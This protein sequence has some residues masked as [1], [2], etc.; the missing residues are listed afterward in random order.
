MTAGPLAVHAGGQAGEA[1]RAACGT[2]LGVLLALAAGCET[3]SKSPVVFEERS[4]EAG[5]D[6]VHTDGSSGKYFITET[7]ASGVGLFDYDGDGDLDIYFV[8]GRPLPTGAA[9]AESAKG[10]TGRNALFRNEGAASGV[11]PKFTDVTAGA[12]VPGTG[13]GIACCAGDYDSDGDLD[14]FVTQ[15]GPDVLYRNNGDGTFTDVTAQAGVGDPALGG[16]CAFG[17]IDLDGDLDL[18]VSNYCIEDLSASRPCLTNNVRHYCAPESYKEALHSL[19]VNNGDGTF[20]DVSESSGIRDP[21]A[22]RGLGVV[23]SD[24]NDDS[25]PEIFVANDSSENYLFLN[26]KNGTFQNIGLEA[27]IAFDLTGTEMG[28]MGVDIADYDGDGR[29]D[30]AVTTFQKQAK[31]I[32][33]RE[34]EK[35][36][37]T[38]R[39]MQA[40]VAGSSLPW[41]SW[42]VKFF[43]YDHD[44]VLDLFIANGHLED[45]IEKYDQSST[46]LQ[47]NK[48]YR[49]AGDGT[50]QDVSNNTGGGLL[51]KRSSRG[52]AFG[53]IDND[54]DVDVVV[55]CSRDRP[56]LLI[57]EGGNRAGNWTQLQL[58][59][60]A[61]NRFAIGARA[62]VRAGKRTWTGEVRSGGSYASQNDLRLHFGLGDVRSVDSVLVRWPSGKTETFAGVKPGRLNRIVEGKGA[63]ENGPAS[64]R[65]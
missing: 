34:G 23:F 27:G 62:M 5:I 12:G 61:P 10:A 1:V 19:F 21:H 54:G 47:Q 39:A 41:V 48:L 53:D 31:V 35:V 13:F 45:Q 22:G 32:F 57:N 56:L 58:A 52:A 9:P 40:G 49:G 46:Y 17:D 50:F 8:S 55:L 15:L 29:L 42:G 65:P 38:D 6:F 26:R 37:F 28:N 33:R 11:L 36:F 63:V 44:G 60:S 4:R 43:D 16:C 18:Y 30:I 59:G 64:G 20:R 24:L 2:A 25:Y 14:I 51:L 3:R 7:L